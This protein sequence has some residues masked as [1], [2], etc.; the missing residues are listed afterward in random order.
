[1]PVTGQVWY[2]RLATKGCSSVRRIIASYVCKLISHQ[3]SSRLNRR[4]GGGGVGGG[5]EPIQAYVHR[6]RLHQRPR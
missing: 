6:T 5:M 3:L 1:M 4:T 2:C